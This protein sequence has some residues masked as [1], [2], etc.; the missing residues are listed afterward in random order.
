MRRTSLT[1]MAA[2][3]A[4]A[5]LGWHL[6]GAAL[7]NTLQ[8]EQAGSRSYDEYRFMRNASPWVGAAMGAVTALAIVG[9]TAAAISVP[10]RRTAD[11]M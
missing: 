9:L 10:G 4:G 1:A 5:L 11:P 6:I 3:V 8:V 2:C 7:I